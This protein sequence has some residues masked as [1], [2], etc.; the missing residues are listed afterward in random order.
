M[1]STH[2]M[3]LAERMCDHIC[4]I[5]QG[6]AILDGD[7]K[8]IKRQMGGNSFRLVATGDLYQLEE[9]PEVEQLAV[10]DNVAKLLLRA[11]RRCGGWSSSSK[12][13]SSTPKSRSWSRSS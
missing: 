13:T 4:L 8:Q 10:Q 12:S 9:M 2:G 1:L 5:S 7:L 11:P 6:R 3:E